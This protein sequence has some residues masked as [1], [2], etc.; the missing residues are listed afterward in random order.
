MSVRS[1][2]LLYEIGWHAAILVILLWLLPAALFGGPFF[3][4]TGLN[5]QILEW[6]AAAY[7]AAVTIYLVL[8]FRFDSPRILTAL[9]VAVGALAV[10]YLGLLLLSSGAYS[11]ALIVAGTALVALGLVTPPIAPASLRLP[12]GLAAL[13]ALVGVLLIAIGR[14]HG[15]AGGFFPTLAQR[16]SGRSAKEPRSRR[17]DVLRTSAYTLSATYY[18]GYLPA[19]NQRAQGGAVAPDPSGRG[20]LLVRSR[21]DLYRL[22]F[23]EGGELH[24]EPIG[25]RVPI[26]NAEFEA[27]VPKVGI[28][29]EDFR[30]ADILPL[31]NKDGTR[32]SCPTPRHANGRQ[33]TRVNRACR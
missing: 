21:G 16:L 20:Y 2:S 12:V 10:V 5:K 30:V 28:L 26:N 7:F 1:R 11:R 3:S 9:L 4:V 24:V 13:A 15:T 31:P 8:V 22:N 29:T 6:F 14:S 27:D 25:L 33:Y 23:D 17:T 19:Y 32:K 18:S